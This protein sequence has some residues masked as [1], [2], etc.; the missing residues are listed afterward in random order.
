[1]GIVAE[2]DAMVSYKGYV[3]L[4]MDMITETSCSTDSKFFP[5]DQQKCRI[6]VTLL[7]YVCSYKVLDKVAVEKLNR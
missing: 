1:M 4:R 3:C 7:N 6:K 5:F 2:S